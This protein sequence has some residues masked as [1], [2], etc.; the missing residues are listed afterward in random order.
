MARIDD[1]KAFDRVPYS[2]IIKT[3]ELIG[4]N[5]KVIALTKKAMTY[6]NTLCAYTQ[7]KSL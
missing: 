1:Q 3:L 2:W 7:K 5:D 6:W 4:I